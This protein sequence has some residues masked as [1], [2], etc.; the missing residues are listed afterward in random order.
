MRILFLMIALACIGCNDPAPQKAF[1]D[2]TTQERMDEIVS[3]LSK[4]EIR[5]PFAN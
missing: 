2:M 1:E 5:D 4:Q 3:Q